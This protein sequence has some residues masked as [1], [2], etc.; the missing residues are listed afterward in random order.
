M[1]RFDTTSLDWWA[2]AT[3]AC[4]AALIESRNIRLELE[5]PNK[6]KNAEEVAQF[7]Q[8][9]AE[10]RR[11]ADRFRELAARNS[12]PAVRKKTYNSVV[13][14]TLAATPAEVEELLGKLPPS[15]AK[16][17]PLALASESTVYRYDAPSN[18]AYY[19]ER[20]GL[21][22]AAWQWNDVRA[23]HEY[24][25]LMAAVVAAE[26]PLNEKL[27]LEF[28]QRATGRSPDD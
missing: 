19:I 2:Q 17:L 25:E 13:E 7:E 27:A 11:L 14:F 20:Q 8:R 3:A 28:F 5:D 10:L 12:V 15:L 26:L 4:H 6:P 18:R 23:M 16:M 22:I 21:A 1:E 24:G 9:E